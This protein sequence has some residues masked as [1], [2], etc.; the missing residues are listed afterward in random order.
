MPSNLRWTQDE[1]NRALAKNKHLSIG[2]KPPEFVRNSHTVTS[3]DTKPLKTAETIPKPK[4]SKTEAEYELI[5]KA[6]HPGSEILFGCYTF[7]LAPK[8]RYKPDLCVSFPNG[9]LHFYEIKG[10]YLFM[11]AH[12]SATTATLSKPR[13]A[14]SLFNHRFFIAQKIDGEWRVEALYGKAFPEP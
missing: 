14:A 6:I 11:G 9:L 12:K 5:L 8:L 1:V 10:K 3:E 2:D 7:L 4:K 13:M